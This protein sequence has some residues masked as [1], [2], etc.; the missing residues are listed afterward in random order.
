MRETRLDT[1]QELSSVPDTPLDWM[2]PANRI[3]MGPSFDDHSPVSAAQRSNPV[4]QAQRRRF[5]VIRETQ[6]ANHGAGK[7]SVSIASGKG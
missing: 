6:N 7:H 4:N 1:T 3:E 2:D 5:R